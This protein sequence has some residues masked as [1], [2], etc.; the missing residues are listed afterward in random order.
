MVDRKLVMANLLGMFGPILQRVLLNHEGRYSVRILRAVAS[1][2]LA[3]FM[4]VS[5]TFCTKNLQLLFTV[6]EREED[7]MIRG[8]IMIALGDLSLRFPNRVEGWNQ[9]IYAR[10]QVALTLLTVIELTHSPSLTAGPLQPHS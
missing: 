4:A 10:L 6:L 2:S 7:E 3:K 1:L 5:D 9:S 8:N